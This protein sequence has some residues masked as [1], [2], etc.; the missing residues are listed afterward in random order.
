MITRLVSRRLLVLISHIVCRRWWRSRTSAQA[1]AIA[2]RRA[3]P[4]HKIIAS[5]PARVPHC[6]G[7]WWKLCV[8][9]VL[10][11][12]GIVDAMLLQ[13]L[14]QAW[15][16]YL[17]LNLGIYLRVHA[18][19]ESLPACVQLVDGDCPAWGVARS[20]P[21]SAWRLGL[22]FALPVR[23]FGGQKKK[24]DRGIQEPKC[25]SQNGERRRRRRRRN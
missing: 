1:V 20:I 9:G 4:F 18:W 16:G 25:G 3:K 10:L 19:I 17:S 5:G 14:G 13:A 6:R 12:I 22:R 21:H 15:G 24:T 7:L 23:R 2:A 8:E 11:R